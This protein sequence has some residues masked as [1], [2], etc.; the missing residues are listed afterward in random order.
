LGTR[1]KGR[2]KRKK[3]CHPE[4]N[5]R[6]I[7]KLESNPKTPSPHV[8]LRSCKTTKHRSKHEFPSCLV[9]EDFVMVS[10]GKWCRVPTWY[11]FLSPSPST[12]KS[13]P[14]SEHAKKKKKNGRPSRWLLAIRLR[15]ANMMFKL[16]RCKRERL[17]LTYISS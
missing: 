6:I 8:F 3:S 10:R 4:K 9:F 11:T 15:L 16:G 2:R 1:G 12:S 14:P 5:Q 17:P 13:T 7:K